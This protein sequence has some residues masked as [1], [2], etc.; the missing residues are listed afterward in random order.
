MPHNR[1]GDA[2]RPGLAK[3]TLRCCDRNASP[4]TVAGFALLELLIIHL[5]SDIKHYIIFGNGTEKT[6]R[7][8]PDLN[9]WRQMVLDAKTKTPEQTTP[10]TEITKSNSGRILTGTFDNSPFN[11]RRPNRRAG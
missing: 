1:L 7:A 10:T 5:P 2:V 6:R 4:V 8:T 9:S 11:P 3:L